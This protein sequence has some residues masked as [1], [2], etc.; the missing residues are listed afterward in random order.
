[1]GKNYADTKQQNDDVG[2]LAGDSNGLPI[3]VLCHDGV[4][5]RHLL[6]DNVAKAQGE[7]QQASEE[8]KDVLTRIKEMYGFDGGKLEKA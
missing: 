1:M 6:R 5:K 3:G 7:Q 2:R 4:E 8:F